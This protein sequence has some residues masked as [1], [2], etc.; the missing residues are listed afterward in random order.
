MRIVTVMMA[1][2][3]CCG[4]LLAEQRPFDRAQRMEGIQTDQLKTYLNLSDQQL[5]DLQAAQNQFREAARP[6]AEQLRQKAQELRQARQQDPVDEA[7]VSKLK[8]DIAALQSQVGTLRTQFQLQAKAVLTADQTAKLSAL[9]QALELM[10]AA[11]QAAALNLLDAPEGA[12]G[13]GGRPP[14]GGRRAPG[15]PPAGVPQP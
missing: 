7:L 14:F 15:G 10:Q 5:L 12:P 11:H 1:V 2:L 13:P 6:I 8:A 3:L 9:Q 4:V